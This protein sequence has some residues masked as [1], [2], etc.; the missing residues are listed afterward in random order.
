M[1]IK[2]KDERLG[3]N[4][5][6]CGFNTSLRIEAPRPIRLWGYAEWPLEKVWWTGPCQHH[7][8]RWY[9]YCESSRV[10]SCYHTAKSDEPKR[11]WTLP[12]GSVVTVE[13]CN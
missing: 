8:D 13:R 4:I 9:T 6:E 2:N 12:A 7:L 10:L 1:I 11:R 3:A 5:I